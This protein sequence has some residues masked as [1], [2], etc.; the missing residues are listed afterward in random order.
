MLTGLAGFVDI[1][2][3][4]STAYIQSWLRNFKNDKTLIVKAASQAQKAVDYILRVSYNEEN[5]SEK[6]IR[7]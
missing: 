6:A 1:T 5:K 7:R 4:N 2:F 3:D